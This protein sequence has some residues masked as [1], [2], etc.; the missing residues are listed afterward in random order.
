MRRREV[1]PVTKYWWTVWIKV[2]VM[3]AVL[4]VA[5]NFISGIV[6]DL[7]DPYLLEE[8]ETVVAPSEETE[9]EEGDTNPLI[10]LVGKV[11]EAFDVKID[12]ENMLFDYANEYAQEMMT[13]SKEDRN[14]I[15]EHL[16]D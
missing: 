1:R 16:A 15:T 8:S 14:V 9:E 7:F 2:A 13:Q 3:A 12:Y 6:R 4:I 5:Y 10:S 11:E